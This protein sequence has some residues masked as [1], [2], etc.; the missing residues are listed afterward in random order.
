[1]IS[2]KFNLLFITLFFC[3]FHSLL[4]AQTEDILPD[5]YGSELISS[6]KEDYYPT[7]I[8]SYNTARDSMFISLDVTSSGKIYCVYTGLEVT[9][10]GSRTPGSSGSEFNTEHVWPQGFFDSAS[11]MVSDIHHLF[12]TWQTVNSIRGSLKFAEISDAE[13]DTWLYNGTQSSSIPVSNINLYSEATTTAFEPREDFKGNIARAIFYFWTLYQDNSDVV[14]EGTNDAFFSDMKETL[15]EWH[16]QDPVN[17]D[18]VARSLRIESIQGNKNPF[19]HDTTL[20][21]RAYFD[22][23]ASPVSDPEAEFS[24]REI[25]FQLDADN[26][27]KDYSNKLYFHDNGT[28]D[29][30]GYDGSKLASITPGNPYMYFVQN[31]GAGEVQLVQD[32]RH[33]F[34]DTVQVY[35]LE[36]EHADFFGE[37]TIS[38]TDFKNISNLWKLDFIDEDEDSIIAMAEDS[39]Y[40]FTTSRNFKIKIEPIASQVEISGE[41]GWRVL[42]FP[43]TNASV[44]EIADDMAVQGIAGGNNATADPNIYINPASDGSAGNGYLSPDDIYSSWGDGLGFLAYFFDNNLNGSTELPLKLDA[45]GQEP[46]SDVNIDISE[47]FTLIGNPFLSNI[48]LDDIQGNGS[49]G[50]NGGLKSPLYFYDSNGLNTVNF[51]T[52]AV[53][54]TWS[55][56]FIERDD[57]ETTRLTIPMSAQTSDEAEVYY[58]SK[59]KNDAYRL[60]ELHL[61]APTGQKDISNKLFFSPHSSEQLDAYDGSKM[62][63]FDGTP[64]LGF[65]HT[66]DNSKTELLVQ[67]ARAENP[68]ENQKYELAIFDAGIS[69]TYILSWPD[70]HNIPE[71]WSFIITDYETGET[72]H[73][74]EGDSYSFQIE[75]R[76]KK[77]HV[78]ELKKPVFKSVNTELMPRLGIRLTHSEMVNNEDDGKADRFSLEQNYP[79]P[80]NPVTTIKYTL[81]Q[82]ADVSLTIYN[83]MGQQVEK[84]VDGRKLAGAYLVSWNAGELASGVYYYR[85]KAGNQV[86]IRKMSLIK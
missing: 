33:L 80:F 28:E 29:Q 31:F 55:G 66:N 13:T 86:S 82:A 40:T 16:A 4:K 38:W 20:I 34:P 9:A 2:K 26:G 1:M 63:P 42:S 12:P 45:S 81:K 27:T 11:P 37:L 74:E 17:A 53:V 5:E 77:Q 61:E 68:I 6:I 22:T 67:D 39:T 46:A 35:S 59:Q 62:Y 24:F 19:I 58:F 71:S 84:L 79:N 15:Y 47:K 21:R 51:G 60:I 83:V 14:S 69:G 52:G 50:I 23:L 3:G 57:N 18:E 75:A 72:I 65:L 36:V 44:T 78:S 32:A 7:T 8:K 41:A 30:D 56:F 10:D 54:S 49:G 70:F 85:L 73:M 48:T 43:V 64:Y 25:S 76:Q